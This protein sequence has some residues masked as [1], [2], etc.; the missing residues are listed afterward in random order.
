MT[1]SAGPS[2]GPLVSA[3][4]SATADLSDLTDFTEDDLAIRLSRL[5][6]ELDKVDAM[7]TLLTQATTE[8]QLGNMAYPSRLPVEGGRIS[9]G[10]GI[11]RDPFTQ[12]AARHTG[13]DFRAPYGAPILASAGGRVTFAGRRN[14]YGNTVEIDHGNGLRTRYG[15]ASRVLVRPGDI[16][17][18]GQR[19]ALVGST[20]RSTGPHLHFEVIRKGV[21]VEPRQYLARKGA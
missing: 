5:D 2:G 18:P 21:Y 4:D 16:V 6:G 13:L 7:V 14:A 1:V 3:T 10:F 9:S 11:R 17:L 12:R 15:H 8:R 19:I 20:G